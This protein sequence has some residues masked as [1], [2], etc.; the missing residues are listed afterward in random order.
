MRTIKG[1]S[2]VKRRHP[3]EERGPGFLQLPGNTIGVPVFTGMTVDDVRY[4]FF[5]LL[6]AHQ[7]RV[8]G[9]PWPPSRGGGG[10]KRM[11]RGMHASS[12]TLI[13]NQAGR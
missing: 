9:D 7:Q 2:V 13:K 12:R 8:Q 10:F 3:V 11:A 5:D 1:D 4:S 6:Q